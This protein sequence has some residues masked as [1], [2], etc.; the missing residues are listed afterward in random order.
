MSI[1]LIICKSKSRYS[2]T[3]SFLRFLHFLNLFKDGLTLIGLLTVMFDQNWRLSLIA[4][5]MIPIASIAAKRLGK[6]MS[7]VVTEAI[8]KSGDLN[9][10]LI[11]LFKNHKIIKIFQ[12]EDFEHERSEN[13]V[14]KL[15]EKTIKIFTVYIRAT[16]IMEIL[17]GIMIAILI[18]YSG[19]LIMNNQYLFHPII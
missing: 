8:E 16:P 4:I 15:K 2:P 9:K 19:K 17:T 18:F 10:Y 12:R 6:R 1:R 11:D 14:N 13:F 5:I 7:K 3:C